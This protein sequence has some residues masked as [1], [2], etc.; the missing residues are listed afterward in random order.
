M[1]AKILL[2]VLI[3][4]IICIGIYL[5][6]KPATVEAENTKAPAKAQQKQTLQQQP[7]PVAVEPGDQIEMIRQREAQ[8]KSREMELV[9]LEKQVTEKIRKLE[10]IESSLKVE[11]EAYK[12]V[13]GERVKFH[14]EAQGCR[15]PD[16]QSGYRGRRAGRPR[17]EGGYRGRH[18]HL[19]GTAESSRNQPE[20]H[21]LPH[22]NRVTIACSCG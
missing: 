13:A 15:N 17:H 16:E 6:I 5:A 20:A 3:I 1:K 22:R 10:A 4:N 8:V 12:V 9:E 11:L 2:S 14:H 19:H 7:Q 21:D 18:T